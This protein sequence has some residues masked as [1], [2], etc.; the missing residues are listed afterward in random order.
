MTG[1]GENF[2][3]WWL[4]AA[5]GGGFL[6]FLGWAL[7]LLCRQPAWRQRLG[8]WGVL[9]SLLVAV[10]S[11]A[12]SWFAIPL[13]P[14]EVAAPSARPHERGPAGRSLR[15][16][17]LEDAARQPA[18]AFGVFPLGSAAPMLF[19]ESNGDFERLSEALF[20]SLWVSPLPG[21]VLK[22][23]ENNRAISPAFSH[24]PDEN[25]FATDSEIGRA[26]V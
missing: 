9:A 17:A 15:D 5:I 13:L 26:H 8:E 10:L 1:F 23:R 3:G 2:A 18:D 6:L 19:E 25:R 16:F 24:E 4:H 7:T 22:E 20:R 14:Q 21:E 12:P 11:F